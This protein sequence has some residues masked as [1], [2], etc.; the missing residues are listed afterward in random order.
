[1]AD[2]VNVPKKKMGTGAKVAIGCGVLLLLGIIITVIIVYSG[3]AGLSKISDNLNKQDDAKQQAFDNPSKIGQEVAVN[4]II[5][6]LTAA[7]NLGSTLKSTYGGEN[8]VANSG[9]FVKITVTIKNNGKD[10]ATVTDLDLYDSQKREFV[11]S[12]DVTG[13]VSD[14]LFLL[15]NIN[16]GIEKTFVA[17]YEIPN[18][19]T[20]LRLKVGD[21]NLFTSD[22]KYISLG[23]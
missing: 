19:A 13:C 3:I 8:C 1:M 7:K 12:S 9:T 16:P 20:G 10:L 22:E 23:F 5:W 11:T 14:T 6:K 15:D 21:L 4:D 2:Q 18:G 17:V